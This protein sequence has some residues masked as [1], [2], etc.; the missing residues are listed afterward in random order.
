M[1]ATHINAIPSRRPLIFQKVGQVWILADV[2]SGARSQPMVIQGQGFRIA[3]LL[4]QT[5]RTGSV[6][7]VRGISPIYS[8]IFRELESV[9][10]H[11]MVIEG[12]K[13]QSVVVELSSV[14]DSRTTPKMPSSKL[15]SFA[16]TDK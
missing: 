14:Y 4:L 11:P 3:T 6:G 7:K 5:S 10:F 2:R 8:Q 13:K 9:L 15:K 16:P 12:Q 1:N